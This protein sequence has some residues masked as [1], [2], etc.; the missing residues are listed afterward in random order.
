[1]AA[2]W[3]SYNRGPLLNRDPK[4]AALLHELAET[5]TALGNYL[6]VAHRKFEDQPKPRQEGLGE[7]LEKSLSQQ[8]RASVALRRL[9]DLLRREATRNDDPGGFR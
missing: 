6:A 5:L 4:K 7:A 9:N 3:D 2:N 1:V 8:E